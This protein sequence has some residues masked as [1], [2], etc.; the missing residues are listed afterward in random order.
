VWRFKDES[1]NAT[2]VKLFDDRQVIVNMS[3]WESAAALEAF[4]FR[5]VHAKFYARRR[6]W[7][8]PDFGPPLA[9]W[10][11]D[12]GTTPDIQDGLARWRMLKEKGPTTYAFGWADLSEASLWKTGRC[13]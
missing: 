12:A 10:W 6:A 1:G 13:A 11:I 4:V 8:D 3:V 7:F 5:T 9:L 2:D